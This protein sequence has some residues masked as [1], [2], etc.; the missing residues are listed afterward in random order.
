ML[1]GMHESR[2]DL[3]RLFRGE[4]TAAEAQRVA[5]HVLVCKECWSR[6]SGAMADQEAAG[7][8]AAPGPL[9][10]LVDLISLF[11]VYLRHGQPDGAISVCERAIRELSLVRDEEGSDPAAREQ[12]RI[13]WT[14]LADGVRRGT[15]QAGAA[16]VM[17][18]YVTAH[19]RTPA[20]ELPVFREQAG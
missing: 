14:K 8:I 7:E 15:V 12:M 6:A 18:R 3:A 5:E 19:W 2:E 20:P 11:G 16:A 13:V 4:G 10:T 9:R 1:E 17:K